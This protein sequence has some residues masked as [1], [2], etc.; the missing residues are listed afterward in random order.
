MSNIPQSRRQTQIAEEIAHLA[1]QFYSHEA[2]RESLITVTHADVSADLA[3]AMVFISVFPTTA[4]KKA[5]AF[6]K[7]ERS[8]LRE[9]IKSKVVFNP[10]PTLDVEIDYGEK[11]RQRIDDLTRSN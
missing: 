7:R 6:A 11:N 10:I 8:A 9:Y 3:N 5:L 1:G 4:E 2:S